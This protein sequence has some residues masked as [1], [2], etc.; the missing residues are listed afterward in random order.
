MH[1]DSATKKIPGS[2]VLGGYDVTR[3]LGDMSSQPYN[4]TKFP[5]R[6]LDIGIGVVTGDSPWNSSNIT[7]LLTLDNSTQ[8]QPR[9]AGTEV[10]LTGADPYL[11]LPQRTCDAITTHLPVS[12]HTSLE[13][14]IWN[15]KDTQY[16]KIV[17]SPSY[18][19]FTFAANASSTADTNGNHTITIKVPFALLDLRLEPPLV[20]EEMAYFPCMGTATTAADGG[21]YVLGRSFLQAAFVGV[22]WALK[23]EGQGQGQGQ[24]NWF[25]AQ[26]PGPGYSQSES[27]SNVICIY[28][29]RQQEEAYS[30]RRQQPPPYS[31]RVASNQNSNNGSPGSNVVPAPQRTAQSPPTQAQ[32]Q[33]PGASRTERREAPRTRAVT[34]NERRSPQSSS[35]SEEQVIEFR[36][37]AAGVV[38]SSSSSS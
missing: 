10:L 9:D 3:V 16:L 1:I 7:G 15:T 28:Q 35:S 22:N 34:R 36:F 23:G 18:L 11:Y 30:Q 19:A 21:P 8:Q 32:A 17:K 13:L 31:D 25:L 26:A 29:G 20:D 6:L 38:S 2:L 24:G 33:Q 37:R 12:Y 14:Y 4:G 5:I 27:E